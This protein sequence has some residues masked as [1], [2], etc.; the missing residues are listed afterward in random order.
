MDEPASRDRSGPDVASR[1][2]SSTVGLSSLAMYEIEQ[3]RR[4]PGPSIRSSAARSLRTDNQ[5]RQ[6]PQSPVSS[7]EAPVAHRPLAGLREHR[8]KT[9]SAMYRTRGAPHLLGSVHRS[10]RPRR[11]PFLEPLHFTSGPLAHV[12]RWRPLKYQREIARD[13]T[14]NHTVHSRLPPV[15]Q[16]DRVRSGKMKKTGLSAV[17]K[18]GKHGKQEYFRRQTAGMPGRVVTLLTAKF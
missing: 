14:R 2:I 18:T 11:W 5:R 12:D 6:N 7:I 9:I 13:D 17:L 1:P 3:K 15:E 16:R 10:S 8:G 4:R